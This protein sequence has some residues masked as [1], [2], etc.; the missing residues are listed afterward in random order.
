MSRFICPRTNSDFRYQPFVAHHNVVLRWCPS[1][2]S[3]QEKSVTGK[4]NP[5]VPYLDER[6][7]GYGL[8]KVSWVTTWRRLGYRFAV[9]P[10]GFAVHNPHPKSNAFSEF[11]HG[12]GKEMREL[13]REFEGELNAT[14][15]LPTINGT[16]A[17]IGPIST[18][19]RP[20]PKP[21]RLKPKDTVQV[22]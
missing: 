19:L 7:H 14:F 12:L 17:G 21:L 11:I 6:F 5:V 4:S 1:A 2:G 16:S 18:C 3:K 15:P 10:E 8:D 22:L 13:Y 20:A 9:L